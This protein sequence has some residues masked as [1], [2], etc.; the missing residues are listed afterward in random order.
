MGWINRQVNGVLLDKSG[1]IKMVR[2]NQCERVAIGESNDRTVS[3]SNLTTSLLIVMIRLAYDS[4][5]TDTCSKFKLIRSIDSEQQQMF[6]QI[7]V[8][9]REW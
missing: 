6:K 1:L 5:A 8:R 7:V 3:P 2:Q 4:Q 9:E